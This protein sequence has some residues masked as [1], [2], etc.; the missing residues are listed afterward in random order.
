MKHVAILMPTHW[1][2]LGGG[3]EYQ[4]QMLCEHLVRS[5]RYR[6]TWLGRRIAEDYR[7]QG[8][9]VR[10]IARH[11]GLRARGFFF[12]AP[13]L[14]KLLRELR[15]D[16]IYQRV[17]CAYTGLAAR[18]AR[19]TGCRMVWHVACDMDVMPETGMAKM[20]LPV[21]RW[22]EKRLLE[23]GVRHAPCIV[24]QTRHQAQLLERHYQRTASAIVRNFHPV[25]REAIDKTGPL[26]VLWVANIKRLKQPELFV[27]L[28]LDF[29]SRADVHF[30]M[31]GQASDDPALM[32]PLLARIEGLPNLTYLG[33]QNQEQVNALFARAHVLVNTSWYEGF[34]NTFIQAWM[35][36]VPV[37]S[38]NADPDGLLRELGL[39]FCAGGDYQALRC[40]LERLLDDDAARAA[41]AEAGRSYAL[42][43][44]TEANIIDLEN[45]IDGREV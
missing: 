4:A 10:Q 24:T 45:L 22:I 31:V 17:G 23:Y 38:L 35:R 12:D 14:D 34:S 3:A 11:D 37:V 21:L 16:V 18:Y 25:P 13:R 30:V 7:P 1:S 36:G 27:D 6:V 8:Y 40:G 19:D 39:G 2:S 20:R 5:G 41:C 9:E 26:T 32:R 33:R 15:P 43:A 29:I 44:H 28:A 42:S